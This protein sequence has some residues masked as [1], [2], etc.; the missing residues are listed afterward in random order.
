MCIR[1]SY[2]TAWDNKK[3]YNED[4]MKYNIGTYGSLAIMVD[5]T[6]ALPLNFE[7]TYS[8]LKESLDEDAAKAAGVDVDAFNEALEG[9]KEAAVGYNK[10]IDEINSRYETAAADNDKAAMKEA[11]ADGQELNKTTL[12]IFKEIQDQLIWVYLS[13]DVTQ[14][15]GIVQENVS[16]LSLSLIHI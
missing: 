4:V 3:T 2:H 11:R 14:K 16:T 5:K 13:A 10:K 9:F 12:K 8:D 15:H 7:Q 1:D 6:P